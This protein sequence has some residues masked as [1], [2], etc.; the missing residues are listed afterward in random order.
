MTAGDADVPATS[1]GAHKA[2]TCTCTTI[3]T[4]CPVRACPGLAW[5]RLKDLT[6]SSSLIP[7]FWLSLRSSVHVFLSVWHSFS[8]CHATAIS[9]AFTTLQH[10]L[11]RLLSFGSHFYFFFLLSVQLLAIF[12]M[13]HATDVFMFSV[14]A[15]HKKVNEQHPRIPGSSVGQRVAEP[16]GMTMNSSCRGG[17]W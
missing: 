4:S 14:C 3:K 2:I 16:E 17:S 1:S 8:G 12:H 11:L 10:F 13:Q 7:D 5:P 9:L 15:A 6:G